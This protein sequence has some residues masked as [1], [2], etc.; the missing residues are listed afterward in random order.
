MELS[1]PPLI[2]SIASPVNSA[3][4]VLPVNKVDQF[5]ALR[6][7]ACLIVLLG[8]CF[9]RMTT[10]VDKVSFGGYDFTWLIRPNAT[11]GMYIF[12]TLSGYLMGNQFFSGKYKISTHGIL[13]F[14][15]AR[16]MRIV[17]LFYAL[18][19]FYL[20]YD[21]A[22]FLRDFHPN[23]LLKIL[24]FTY[25]IWPFEYSGD[26]FWSIATEMQFYLF[27]PALFFICKRFCKNGYFL[28]GS[29]VC[30]LLCLELYRAQV[31]PKCLLPNGVLDMAQYQKKIYYPLIGNLDVFFIGFW[32][33][34]FYQWQS[35]TD[36]AGNIKRFF[37]TMVA[38]LQGP[39][40]SKSSLSRL[41]M[42]WVAIL[43]CYVATTYMLH[44]NQH[45]F[46]MR[47]GVLNLLTSA[48]T[49]IFI[50]IARGAETNTKN[51]HLNIAACI[52][53]PFRLI[54]CVG[55]LSYGVYLWHISILSF[56]AM[57]VIRENTVHDYLVLVLSTSVLSILFATV[58]YLGI[59]KPINQLRYKL[60]TK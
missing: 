3:A 6:G 24:T 40:L 55:V 16:I 33:N 47:F 10:L 51:A 52:K 58:T 11:I 37:A 26:H 7:I 21:G 56:I 49:A 1:P 9:L 44:G 8:H 48:A 29:L 14:F 41:G 39:A 20:I 31:F 4:I 32:L 46:N 35:E 28:I 18:T 23:Q 50:V 25:S 2:E 60:A 59:E 53:N 38:K 36:N 5:L 22:D 13:N 57:I 27:V 12:F 54:D 42:A 15:R 34:M 43:S 19:L 30:V 45:Y 17:P